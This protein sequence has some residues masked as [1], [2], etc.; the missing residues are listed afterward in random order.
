MMSYEGWGSKSK[1]YFSKCSA[2]L[3]KDFLV[4]DGS[5][6]MKFQHANSNWKEST[7]DVGDKLS[8]KAMC[9]K[10]TKKPDAYVDPTKTP[11]DLCK[12]LSCR[13]PNDKGR[14]SF[15]WVTLNHPPGDN[16]PCAK[17]KRCMNGE[18]VA[19]GAAVGK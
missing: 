3:M 13:Y 19:A 1:F 15:N 9:V 12:N 14:G 8:M 2:R 17:G 7:R 6:C 16:V 11:D 10:Y 4:S 18:C 5:L